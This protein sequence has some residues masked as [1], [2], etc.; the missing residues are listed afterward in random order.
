M[1][2]THEM[3]PDT[4]LEVRGLKKYFPIYSKGFLKKVVN[5]VKASNDLSFD[6]KAGT[7]LGLVGESGCGKTTTART[8]LRAL[9]P[10]DGHIYFRS[11]QMG[12][13]SW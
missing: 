13:V 9:A 11:K 1:K 10:T 6:L 12:P 2:T 3:H 8:L 4:I 7:T 5:T